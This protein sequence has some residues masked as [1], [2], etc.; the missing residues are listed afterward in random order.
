MKSLRTPFLASLLCLMALSVTA[1][2]WEDLDTRQAEIVS[3]YLKLHPFILDYCDCCSEGEVYLMRVVDTRTVP[4]SYNTAKFSII[5]TVVRIAKMD[6]EA[7]GLPIPTNVT[8][9]E[10]EPEEFIVSLNYT[11][12]YS[13][14]DK[15]A[16]PFY[17]LVPYELDHVCQ[18]SARYPKP[19]G[20]NDIQD[21]AYQRWFK[22][23]KL[24]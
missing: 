21:T 23:N 13:K 4:C 2:P 8:P 9:L 16:V 12:V 17:K 10:G 6:R 3:K 24:K 22:K 19:S 11:Y 20:S 15:M 14:P 5:A 7:S 1:D 18:L